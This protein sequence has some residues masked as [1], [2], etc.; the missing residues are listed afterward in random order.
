VDEQ[1]ELVVVGREQQALAASLGA[2]EPPAFERRQRG[3]EGLQRRDVRRPG[4]LDRKGANGIVQQ[5]APRLH[6]GQFGI[7]R[8]G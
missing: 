2:G 4:L 8:R 1:H 7:V 3:V 5:A 6:F